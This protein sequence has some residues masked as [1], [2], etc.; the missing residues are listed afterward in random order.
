MTAWPRRR[1]SVGSLASDGCAS[2]SSERIARNRTPMTKLMDQSLI[3]FPFG[4][5]MMM[6]PTIAT[7]KIATLNLTATLPV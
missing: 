4:L 1:S 7:D 3:P 5:E 6:S 2:E